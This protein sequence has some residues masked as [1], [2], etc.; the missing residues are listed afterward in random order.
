M[1]YPRT[2]AV[3]NRKGGVGKTT[4]SRYVA[5]YFARYQDKR[6]LSID[7]DN[8][9]NLSRLLLDMDVTG[10]RIRPPLHPQYDPSDTTWGG[11]GSSADLF[12]TGDFVSYDVQFPKPVAGWEILPGDSQRLFE[13]ERH[14]DPRIRNAIIDLLRTQLGELSD[15][16]D[17][18]VIDTGPSTNSLMLA[19]LRAAT[20]IL[21]PFTPEPQTASNLNQILGLVRRE[22]EHRQAR[23]EALELL[24]ILVNRYRPNQ[25][26][27]AGLVESMRADSRYSRLMLPQEIHDRAIFQAMDAQKPS[28]ESVFDI[29]RREHLVLKET[30]EAFGAYVNARLFGGD[31]G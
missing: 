25:N 10:E 17:V 8:Q 4:I 12:L 30:M 28:P 14:D 6:V 21:I 5:E 26:V 27:H 13:L 11:R 24:G 31:N 22:N 9:C 20:H 1:P 16:Y 23:M 15:D 29:T 3:I 18:V 2:I 7:L 19:A